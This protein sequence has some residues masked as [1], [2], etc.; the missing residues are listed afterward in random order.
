MEVET[1]VPEPTTGLAASRDRL[2]N[3]AVHRRTRE[4]I[5]DFE[6]DLIHVHNF[7]RR[8]SVA[9]FYAARGTGVATLLTVHDFQLFCPRTWALRADGSPCRDPRLLRCAFGACRGGLE[10]ASGRVVYALNTLR[11]R[12]AAH[13]VRRHATRI[14][15]PSAALAERLGATLR[16]DVGVL[17]SRPAPAA[18]G[19]FEP[20]ASRDLLFVGRLSREKGLLEFLRAFPTDL[21]LTIAGEGPQRAELEELVRDRGLRRVRFAG[22]VPHERVSRMIR[23]HGGI[24][25][26]SVC[27]ENSPMAVA[28]AHAEGRPVVGSNRG[29][30]PE[31]V[32]DGVTGLLFEPDVPASVA[33]AL[34][35]WRA[36]GPAEHEAMA[37]RAAA[38]G[39]AA[40][41]PEAGFAL[42]E[43]EYRRAIDQRNWG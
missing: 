11:Q 32:E 27:L 28:E 25:L 37:R 7:L 26:P 23:E 29:G 30:I 1:F 8:L 5:R 15:A 4:L 3:P 41:D 6:P 16:R 36:L 33:A 19:P 20:P 21:S 10:G 18:R 14:V 31:M 42:V 39:A 43:A 12:A 35:K 22:A 40:A 9:P 2:F 38:R 34:A 17:P 13:V 24:V